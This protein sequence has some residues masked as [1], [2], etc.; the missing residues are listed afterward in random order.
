MVS[1]IDMH[2]HPPTEEYI[3]SG[4]KYLQHAAEYFGMA[5]IYEKPKSIGEMVKEYE[6]AGVGKVVLVAW[7]AETYTGL[8]R[9][10]NDYIAHIVEEYPLFVGFA[11]VDPWKG[12][13]AIDELERAIT[14]LGLEGVKFQQAAQGFYPNDRRFYP[15]YEKCLELDIPIQFHTGTTG[16]GAGGPGGDSI[17]LDYVRPIYIDHVAA[18]FPDLTI[19]GLHPSWPWVS[20]S[21]AIAMHKPNYYLDLSGWSPRYFPQE[22]IHY[23]NSLLQDKCLFGTD[24]PFITPTRWLND[25]EKLGF[26]EE[27]KEKILERNARRL[28]RL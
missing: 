22:L 7:D 11:S 8:P 20:E 23:A 28:L 1:P 14:E 26:K 6:E 24:Y 12:K 16:F 15:L 27:V 18:D 5:E 17:K 13:V 19:I 3:A 9:V 10:T 21:L 4:G 2:A 25:F